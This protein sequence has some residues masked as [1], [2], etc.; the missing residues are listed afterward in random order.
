MRSSPSVSGPTVAT[1]CS[2]CVCS[3]HGDEFDVAFVGKAVEV[4]KVI[5]SSGEA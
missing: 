2:S 3:V 1:S 5:S 4:L